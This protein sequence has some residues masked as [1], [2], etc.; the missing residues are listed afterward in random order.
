MADRLQY[1]LLAGGEQLRRNVRPVR[2]PVPDDVRYDPGEAARALAPQVAQIRAR[3]TALEPHLRGPRIVIQATLRPEYLAGTHFPSAL[4]RETGIQMVGGA[5]LHLAASAEAGAE[6]G[7]MSDA[8]AKSLF[9]AATDGQLHH[10]QFLLEQPDTFVRSEAFRDVRKFAAMRLPGP[11]DVLRTELGE[12]PTAVE[13]AVAWEA[14]LHPPVE[15]SDTG[16]EQEM[17]EVFGKW[18]AYVRQ[19]GG[20]EAVRPGRRVVVGGVCYVPVIL[21]PALARQA[22]QFNPLRVLRPMPRIRVLDQ[23]TG[24]ALELFRPELPV[25]QTPPPADAHIVVFDGGL[26]PDCPFATP[27]T[28]VTSLTSEP[29]LAHLVAHGTIVTNAVIYGYPDPGLPLP[30]PAAWVHHYRVL[31]AEPDPDHPFG[32]LDLMW[33]LDQIEDVV[34][35]ERPRVV[36][37]SIGPAACVREDDPPHQWTLRLDQLAHELGVLFVSGVGNTGRADPTRGGHR[38]QSPADMANGLAVGACPARHDGPARRADYSGM[39]PGRHGAWIR[40]HGVQFGG[41]LAGEP[42]VGIGPRGEYLADEGT[43]YAAP[44]ATHGIAQ[45]LGTLGRARATPATLRAFPVHFAK[46]RPRSQSTD[47]VGYGRFPDAYL[48]LLGCSPEEVTVLYEDVVERGDVASLR[49]PVPE[50]LPPDARVWVHFTLCYTCPVDPADPMGYTRAG[51][52]CK[53]RPHSNRYV[54]RRLETREELATV[55]VPDGTE[56]PDEW[57]GQ[58]VKASARPR[59]VSLG[60]VQGTEQWRRRE[61]KWDTTV[62]KRFSKPANELHRP[63]LELA[64]LGRS[65]GGLVPPSRR[66][67]LPYTLLATM[68]TLPGVPLYRLVEAQFP[69]LIPVATEVIIPAH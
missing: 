16:G 43:S 2:G 14:V 6:E 1:P 23:R 40:P 69:M 3:V 64:H 61:G 49:L 57:E 30:R 17:E 56:P 5:P 36:H 59:T 68:R 31:P 28:Q 45:L 53:L 12:A 24:P 27:F 15:G 52:E 25:D 22:A 44:L 55:M 41:E 20:D 10:L 11:E 42:F 18:V 8:P 66:P 13:Q 33:I 67:A 60:A 39:G 46:R 9:L 51:F 21:S 26:D 37:L 19:L 47:H 65:M 63:E 34:R 7:S 48:S 62:V 29:P 35:A 32:D 50:G 4:L 54:L 38:V 58:P